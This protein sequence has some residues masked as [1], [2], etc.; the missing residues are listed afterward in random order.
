MAVARKVIRRRK[1]IRR[2]EKGQAHVH[3]SFNN[4]IVT[5]TDM[6]G[7]TISWC[8]GGKLNYKGSK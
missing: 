8:S 1:D 3:A 5:V 6:E 4:T 2:I 7:N